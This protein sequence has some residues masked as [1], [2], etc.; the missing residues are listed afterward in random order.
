MIKSMTGFGVAG[1]E[2]EQM[3]IQIEV[4]S[5]NSKILDLSIRSPRQ[6]SDKES[7]IR[8]LAQ[9]IL[10]RGKV[11]ISIEFVP[12][13]SENLPVTINQ[14]LFKAYFEEFKNLA[15]L[16]GTP[17]NDLFKLALQSPNVIT[18]I[19]MERE[20]GDDWEQT[21]LVLE[22]ALKKCDGFRIDEGASLYSKLEE[23]ITVIRSAFE[24]V[25]QEEPIRKE[26]IRQRIRNHFTQWMEENSFD[27]NRFEQE[28]IY[29]F[30]K[31]DITEE[32][33]R[34]ETHLDYFMK[35]LSEENGQ[36]KKLG[37][38]SQEIGREINTIGSKANDAEIQKHVILMK[39]ELEKIKEQSLNVL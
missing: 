1:F 38:I 30:E 34:L 18:S 32:L 29:Y 13:G 35:S 28:L 22:E 10:D 12:R 27:A 24:R 19:P 11:S 4:R 2:N 5:L 23:N 8:G 39:D 31:L 33:V 15:E 36:G 9:S 21:K 7:E 3:M 26:R 6:F 37:F 20:D 25:K 14:G 16:V 17:S